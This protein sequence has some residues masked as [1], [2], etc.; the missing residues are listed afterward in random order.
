MGGKEQA[1]ER[2]QESQH[3]AHH[4]AGGGVELHPQR[5]KYPV[6]RSPGPSLQVA[7]RQDEERE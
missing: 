7:C 6:P 3:T 4:W 2:H 1:F 5:G